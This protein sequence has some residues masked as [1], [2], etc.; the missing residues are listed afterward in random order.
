M[1]LGLGVLCFAAN[2]SA[3]NPLIMDQFTADPT[4]RVFE[5]RI[6][7]YPSHDILAGPG[8]GRAG[9]FC[10]EDY[11]VFSSENLADWKDHG[12]IV[13][14]N[15]VDWVDPTSYSMWA[16]DCVFK[17][18]KYYFYFPA[19]ARAGAAG[20]RGRRS[21]IGVAVSDKPYGPFKPETA[22]IEGALGIDPCVLTDKDGTA[23]LYY[24]MK[25][26][27]VARLTDNMLE[28]DSKPEVIQNLPTAGLIEGPFVFERN[29]IYYLTY[30][31]V[32]NKTE[33]LEYATGSNPM[34]PFEQKGVIMDESPSGCWTNHPSIVEYKGQWY[35]FYHDKDLSPKFD[36]NRSIRADYLSFNEDGTINKVT[37][38]LRGVGI[39]NA[40]SKIQIDR[41]SATS[42]EGAS[43]SFLND[44]NK[45]EGWKI[46]LSEKNA[47]VQ[48]NTVD[49]GNSDLKS[50]NVKSV[51]STGGSIE[52]H[53]DKA[54]G[55]L[56]AEVDIGEDADW[57]VVNS[58][59]AT[60][61]SDIGGLVVT[62]TDKS[63]V[64]IDW[65]S[66]E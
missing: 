45:R 1:A 53:L 35:L 51:S 9:W 41:Y 48:Y 12:V 37:P 3:Q 8:R 7:V 15:D 21:G 20:G 27:F 49:F 64:E 43:V 65:I 5:G 66:F 59:L 22:P 46:S 19:R 57:S 32:Q 29:G 23:Y 38:T 17:N 25:R 33:R 4:A 26:V 60:V 58:K 50:A 55:P 2:T 63:N 42:Q 62:L 36:K 47:W 13:S 18:G 14:Q 54:D 30:P 10:M 34:G 44:A 52:I 56:L 16:P 39:T 61:P 11:H 24:S 6:Y 40:K 31:H 28:L